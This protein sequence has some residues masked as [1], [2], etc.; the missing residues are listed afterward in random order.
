MIDFP[1]PVEIECPASHF[2]QNGIATEVAM[3]L[4]P[5]VDL[6]ELRFPHLTSAAVGV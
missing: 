6:A 4:C 5:V 2:E 3:T 1:I